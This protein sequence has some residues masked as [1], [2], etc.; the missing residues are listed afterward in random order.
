[1]CVREN[2]VLRDGRKFW[3]E[4]GMKKILRRFVIIGA[5]RELP[6][7]SERWRESCQTERSLNAVGLVGESE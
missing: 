4:L 3:V 7:V 6:Y 2:G 5:V 1:M